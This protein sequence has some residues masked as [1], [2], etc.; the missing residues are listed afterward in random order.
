MSKKVKIELNRSGVRELLRSGEMASICEGYAKQ[1]L[2]SLGEG[3]EVSTHTGANRVNAEVAA[4]T[5]KARLENSKSNTI[6][7]AIGGV[8]S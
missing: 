2:A 7:R 5:Y 3:Y 8:R 4:V 1:A 6:L